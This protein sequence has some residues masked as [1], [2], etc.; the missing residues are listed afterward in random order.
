M[1]T[2]NSNSKFSAKVLL[3]EDDQDLQELFHDYFTPRGYEV[4]CRGSAEEARDVFISQPTGAPIDLVVTDFMLPNMNGVELIESL[5]KVSP[6]TPIIL[7][8]AHSSFDL[9]MEA[10][11]KGAFDFAVKPVHFQQ[12]ALTMERA[13]HVSRLTHEN[14]KLKS[15]VDSFG[16]SSNSVIIRS[17]S[18]RQVVDLAKRVSRSNSTVL[19]TGE[20]GTGKEVIAKIIHDSSSRADK[21]FIAINCSA[22]PE[23]LLETE[24]F[25]HVKGSFTGADG[26]KVGLFEEANGGTIFLDEIGELSQPLQAKLLRVLQEKKIRRVGDNEHRDIDVRILAATHKNLVE[27]VKA[28][29]F[30]DDLYF[31]LNVIPIKI[32][33]L[34]DRREDIIP[35]AMHFLK[36]FRE[37]TNSSARGFSKEALG[38]LLKND[39]SGNVRELENSVERALVLCEGD[40]IDVRHFLNPENE[41]Q[42][43]I[44]GDILTDENIESLIEQ[45][46]QELAPPAMQAGDM[47]TSNASASPLQ[48]ASSS[49]VAPGEWIT[50]EDL[51]MR[52]IKMVLKE[53][54]GVKEKAAK[55]LDVDRKTLYR[56]LT[57][58]NK[59]GH[60]VRVSH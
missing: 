18:M 29:R 60:E 22:I 54:D 5:K 25:G 1:T 44:G 59:T 42:K 12:M 27:E 36:R 13:I 14:K 33:A 53:V 9:A 55:I 38:F 21:P 24:L 2:Q 19:I 16:S 28:K 39:W 11:E 40:L 46:S 4:I 31:R 30:R 35:L 6:D 52:Y 3:L 50:L 48:S 20:S 7:M 34:R 26:N 56:K 32:P 8:T 10:I 23:T 45:Q 49:L 47:K 57:A 51:E 37:K 43:S 15:E 58:H 41:I 17:A